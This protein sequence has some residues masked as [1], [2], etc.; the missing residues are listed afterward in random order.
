MPKFD[1]GEVDLYYEYVGSGDECI[2]LLNGVMMST[3]SWSYQT[4]VLSKHYRVLLSDFRGQGRSSKPD[5]PYSFDMHI[6]DLKNLL[7][8]LG[9]KRANFVGTSYGA[10]VGMYFAIKFPEYV[11]SLTVATAVS[12]S[13]YLLK[14][15]IESWCIAARHALELGSSGKYDFFL[16]SAP[17]NF[18]TSF[19]ETNPTFLEET[20]KDVSRFPDEWFRAFIHLC[21]C[22]K[23]LDITDQLHKIKARTLIIS[24]ENDTLKSVRYSAIMA[25]QIADSESVIVMEAGHSMVIESSSE[26]LT[27][28]MGFINKL[29]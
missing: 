5:T 7:D 25:K 16:L 11:K 8:H 9:I 2:V 22:F 1:T 29:R 28:L 12:E 21:E 19:L 4:P 17:Y 3:D 18:S 20:A 15:K 24:A 26:F 27:C 6:N 14:Q 10:E 23:S 13:D